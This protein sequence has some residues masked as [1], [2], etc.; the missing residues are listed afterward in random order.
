MKPI[1]IVALVVIA[2]VIA[3]VVSS[4]GST[5]QYVDFAMAKE[6]AQDN[7][8]EKIHIVGELKKDQQG[9]VIGM[10]YDPLVNPNLTRFILID[11]KGSEEEVILMEPKPA[12]IEKSEKVVVIGGFS[13]SQFVVDK[14]ILKCPSKYEEKELKETAYVK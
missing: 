12:D 10:E 1:H 5:S 3:I 9:N 13:G 14:V 4:I 7:P 2:V 6:I 11:D 8:N